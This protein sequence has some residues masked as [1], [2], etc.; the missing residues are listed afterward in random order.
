VSG[1]GEELD[2]IMSAVL[3]QLRRLNDADLAEVVAGRSELRVLPKDLLTAFNQLRALGEP[4]LELL[5]RGEGAL[6]VV[7][8]EAA[9]TPTIDAAEVRRQLREAASEA[10]AEAYLLGLGAPV[11]ALRVLAQ[12]L[13]VRPTSPA[14]VRSIVGEIVKVYV[15]GRVS[16]TAIRRY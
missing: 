5:A 10:Q 8:V 1:L 2:K 13:G 4:A 12:E 15:S 7:P 14:T 16:A 6:A 11:A 3:V 9:P